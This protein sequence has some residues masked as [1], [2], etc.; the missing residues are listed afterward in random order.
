MAAMR[1]RSGRVGGIGEADKEKQNPSC[2][3]IMGM[4]V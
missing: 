1:K 2:K 4:R 3:L